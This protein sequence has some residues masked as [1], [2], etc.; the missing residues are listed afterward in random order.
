MVAAEL[1]RRCEQ[2]LNELRQAETHLATTPSVQS[3]VAEISPELREAFTALGQRLPAIWHE[4]VLTRE[5]QK[6]LLRCLIDKVV[7]HRSASD[8][9]SLR[10]FWKGEQVSMFDLPVP[11]GALADYSQAEAMTQRILSLFAEGQADAAIA[12]Q[13][14]SEGFRSPMGACVL[15]STVQ[16]IRLRHGCMQQRHQSHPRHIAGSLTVPQLAN[17]LAVSRHWL[18]DRIHNGVIEIRPDGATGL[19]LFHDE[20]ATLEQLRQLRDGILNKLH[21]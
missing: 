19:Y 16:T 6:S 20:P 3:G 12:V 2:A 14:T 18:Y 13:L 1:E 10:I 9:L 8:C 7:V 4:G 11:V 21:F 17:A 15:P 5:Q